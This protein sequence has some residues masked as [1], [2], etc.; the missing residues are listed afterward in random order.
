MIWQRIHSQRISQ[1]P[2]CRNPRCGEPDLCHD[3]D[4]DLVDDQ[5]DDDDDLVDDQ[6]DVGGHG[7]VEGWE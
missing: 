4:D 3:D 5:Q 7:H 1:G 2:A 6:H